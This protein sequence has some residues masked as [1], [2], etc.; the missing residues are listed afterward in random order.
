M[1]DLDPATAPA[2]APAPA[3]PKKVADAIG[4]PTPVASK[5]A[6]PKSKPI[7][8]MDDAIAA[9]A[10]LVNKGPPTAPDYKPPV[11]EEFKG[12]MPEPDPVK[13]FGS[14]ASV[15]GVL[16]GALTRR[17]LTAALN[18]SAEAMK[19]S[20]ANDVAA[21]QDAKDTWEKNMK[22]V[23]E[24]AK[25]QAEAYK[26]NF[27]K[28]RD[29]WVE[30]MRGITTLNAMYHTRAVEG[31]E[32]SS[33]KI[34]QAMNTLKIAEMQAEHV[35]NVQLR[36]DEELDVLKRADDL[37]K[38]RG[39]PGLKDVPP[40]VAAHAREM[41]RLAR[42][43]EQEA[44]KRHGSAAEIAEAQWLSRPENAGKSHLDYVHEQA[45]AQA[46]GRAEGADKPTATSQ[47]ILKNAGGGN[48]PVKDADAIVKSVLAAT[49]LT[50]LAKEADSTDIQFGELGSKIA[51]WSNWWQRNVIGDKT[52]WDEAFGGLST[53]SPSDRNAV[54]YKD[55][56][57]RI[58][59][60]ERQARGGGVLPGFLVKTLTPL[61]DPKMISRASFQE[62]MQRRSAELVKGTMQ[63]EEVI[64]NLVSQFPQVDSKGVSGW[65]TPTSAGG[66]A[67]AEGGSAL[68]PGRYRFDPA[69]GGMVPE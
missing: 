67:P 62:I 58:L 16:L 18:A 3:D 41:A 7:R 1:V 68:K 43:Q 30:T 65:L 56:I 46:G 14:W 48:R 21:Y 35:R 42:T 54:W 64:K 23:T 38:E 20:R 53:L 69:T 17:P 57:F 24:N 55:A 32:A 63:P 8:N 34:N 6:A 9:Q 19:A 50:A 59:E 28:N 44:A 2:P 11:L 4:A 45:K 52:T 27:D 5:P 61:M 25:L 60:A 31:R 47:E 13:A 26:M 15:A 51:G 33:A 39:F 10:A 36:Y 40:E 37:V 22:E 49:Q 12:K 29:N 66:A